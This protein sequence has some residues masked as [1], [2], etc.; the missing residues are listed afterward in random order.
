MPDG[1]PAC[2]RDHPHHDRYHNATEIIVSSLVSSHGYSSSLVAPSPRTSLVNGAATYQCQLVELESTCKQK[3]PRDMPE[4]R[5]PPDTRRVRLRFIDVGAHPINWVPVDE[6]EPYADNTQ[7][8]PVQVYRIS[9]TRIVIRIADEGH[10]LARTLPRSREWN[11]PTT[12]N[13][14][15]LDERLLEPIVVQHAPPQAD[16]ISFFNS[17]RIGPLT[18]TDEA[19]LSDGISFLEWALNIITYANFAYNPLLHQIVRGEDPNT[20]R[21]ALITAWNVETV[22]IVIQNLNGP[23]HPFHLHGKPFWIMARGQGSVGPETIASLDLN[24]YNPLR[25]DTLGLPSGQWVLI[26]LVADVPGVHAFHCHIVFHQA[27]G[28]FGALVIQPDVIRNFKSPKANY[29]L[30][31]RGN[32]N[33]I[34]PGRRRRLRKRLFDLPHLD[35]LHHHSKTRT[36]PASRQPS[37]A[38]VHGQQ[39]HGA[40]DATIRSGQNHQR[41]MNERD[42]DKERKRRGRLVDLVGEYCYGLKDFS[43]RLAGCTMPPRKAPAT[44]SPDVPPPAKRVVPARRAAQRRQPSEDGAAPQQE[45]PQQEETQPKRHE[46]A[47]TDTLPLVPPSSNFHTVLR[48][49]FHSDHWVLPLRADVDALL[50]AFEQRWASRTGEESPMQ[51]IRELWSEMGWKWV[52]LLGCPEGPLRRGWGQTVVRA[53]VEHLKVGVAPLRQ[54]AA[55][56]A[57][58]LLTQTQAK[59]AEKLF[60]QVDPVA[61]EYI[62]SLP[63]RLPPALDTAPFDPASPAASTPPPSA[64]LSYALSV[65]L[66][67][68]SFHLVPSVSSQA[69]PF[70]H[71][72]RNAKLVREKRERALLVLG[73]EEELKRITRG[74]F[75]AGEASEERDTK[76]K[77]R[78]DEAEEN[79]A[80]A[81]GEKAAADA[82]SNADGW[83]ANRLVELSTV[84]TEAK[85]ASSAGIASTAA[86]PF[87]PPRP[88][89]LTQPATSLQASILERAKSMMR[90]RLRE[91]E[92]KEA[93]APD[94]LDLVGWMRTRNTA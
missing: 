42:E 86:A 35:L 1:P 68:S 64:D 62:T 36:T 8:L 33:M 88:S 27:Q 21:I 20:G 92:V 65:L 28:L 71:V 63:S 16:Q 9:V 81:A 66:R 22:D 5:F 37:H 72:E 50:S 67:T 48:L 24:T 87:L 80:G 89:T 73:A 70:V 44:R 23:E 29:Q 61:F 94:L 57:L 39:H 76:R 75:D 19:G 55:F 40:H 69:W 52:S 91:L 77:R 83:L 82:N 41:A 38:A 26:R 90:D 15:D 17:S 32:P 85:T 3:T 53:F 54:A 43:T 12:G 25:R 18:T 56:L 46:L 2:R 45:E 49:F 11:D 60:I 31:A 93:D 14:T 30:C 58:Y 34:D 51:V 78:N 6:H 13:W 47:Q 7:K 10:R 84:Y 79:E 4:L 59:G 74:D